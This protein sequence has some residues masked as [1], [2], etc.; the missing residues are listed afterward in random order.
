MKKST[1]ASVG[2]SEAKDADTQP[3]APAERAKQYARAGKAFEA[4]HTLSSAPATHAVRFKGKSFDY[5]VMQAENEQRRAARTGKPLPAKTPATP[6][7]PRHHP[8]G[9]WRS[10]R[11]RCRNL[12]W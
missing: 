10:A 8:R 11:W 6:S 7:D 2:S 1:T 12:C 5:D 3:I 4:R 9:L